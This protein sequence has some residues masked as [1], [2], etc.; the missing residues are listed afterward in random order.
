MAVGRSVLAKRFG[1]TYDRSMPQRT[2]PERSRLRSL[3]GNAL[4]AHQ[5]SR[6]NGLLDRILP[7]NEFYATKLT[8]MRLPLTSLDHLKELPYTFKSGLAD[9]KFGMSGNHT[10]PVDR[11]TRWHQTSGTRGR[12]LVVLDTTEDWAWW[13]DC[14]QHVL[15]AA[16]ITSED[17]ILFAFSF[18]PFIGFWSAFDAAKALG[19]LTIPGGGANTLGRLELLRTSQATVLMCTP[20][21]ALHLAEVAV[22]R[23]IDVAALAVKK[24]ILAGEPGGSI[25][26]I[27]QRIEEAWQAQ[28]FDHS[29]ATEVGPWGFPDENHKGLHILESEFIAEFLSVERG[30]AATEGELS[31]L[32]LTCLGRTGCPV[33]RYRTGDLVRPVWQREGKTRFVLLDGG[34]LGRT[35]DMMII[36]GV[37]IFPSAIE[38]ILRSFPEVIEYRMTAERVEEMDRLMIEIE[39]RLGN[40]ERVSEEL[41]LRLGLKVEVNQ[42][43]VGSLPRFE[44]KAKRFIDNR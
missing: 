35:D 15:D 3:H 16:E 8:A 33:I 38:Q 39:D 7:D 31:E 14:W 20:S 19:C 24:I 28:V 41:R 10:Y 21:Y 26:A 17:R 42:V 5:L 36:R 12:P 1:A 22:S 9:G 18:G 13:M 2:A 37:N 40:P 30:E 11:Y 6:L 4:K 29:G 43:E 34:V 27:R 25:P 23:Q 32:V 44:G